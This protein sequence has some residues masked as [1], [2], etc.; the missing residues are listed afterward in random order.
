[1]RKKKTFSLFCNSIWFVNI[2]MG[3]LIEKS[4]YQ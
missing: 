3:T 2:E 4:L 1:M